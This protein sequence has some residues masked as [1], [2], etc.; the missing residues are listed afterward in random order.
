M[1]SLDNVFDEAEL[2]A[3]YTRVVKGLGREATFVCEPKI[4]GVSIAVVY[5]HGRYVR[6]LPG[7]TARPVR[8]S[9]RTC[10]PSARFPRV[11]ERP[12]HRRGSKC[13]AR[14]F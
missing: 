8:M 10:A 5:E 11:Y 12:I 3:W 9:P 1:L 4:D 7:A 2:E 6:A 13:A 14:Y